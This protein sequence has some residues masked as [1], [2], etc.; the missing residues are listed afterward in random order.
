MMVSLSLLCF[1]RG[2]GHRARQARSMRMR[3]GAPSRSQA[4]HGLEL[5]MLRLGGAG[6]AKDVTCLRVRTGGKRVGLS[7]AQVAEVFQE[8][9]DRPDELRV[10]PGQGRDGERGSGLGMDL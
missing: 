7:D 6:L 3:T 8:A 2:A 10:A 9:V 4:S 5:I 1:A